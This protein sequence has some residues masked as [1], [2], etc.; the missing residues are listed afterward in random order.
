MTDDASG[1]EARR[2]APQS[3]FTMREVSIGLVV[4]VLGSIIAFGIPLALL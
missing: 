2:T 1:D 3:P 4:T